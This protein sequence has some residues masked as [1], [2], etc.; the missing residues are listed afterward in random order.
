[1][2]DRLTEIIEH[3]QKKGIFYAH[4]R[5]MKS[6]S[7]SITVKHGQLHVPIRN[8]SRG[9]GIRILYNGCW[10]FATVSHLD[11]H[12]LRKSAD[13]AINIARASAVTRKK[14]A[15]LATRDDDQRT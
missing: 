4:A 3:I 1:M 14:P 13:K 11:S 12:S 7:E 5:Y 2:K 8:E 9:A 15:A 10:G 6:Q